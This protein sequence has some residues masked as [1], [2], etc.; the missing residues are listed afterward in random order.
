VTDL[1]LCH[2]CTQWTICCFKDIAAIDVIVRSGLQMT[3]SPAETSL[4]P[5]LN[6]LKYMNSKRSQVV[7]RS[8]PFF[9]YKNIVWK[10]WYFTKDSGSFICALACLVW[11]VDSNRQIQYLRH[12]QITSPGVQS[13]II[14][15]PHFLVALAYFDVYKCDSTMCYLIIPETRNSS[16]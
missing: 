1:E 13:V 14:L 9:E 8:R 3:L 5:P 7:W 10:P 4:Q 6:F 2:Y 12:V 15:Q 16:N 11:L